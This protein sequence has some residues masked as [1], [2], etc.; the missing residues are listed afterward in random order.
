MWL[1]FLERENEKVVSLSDHL[2]LDM[3]REIQEELEKF[4]I[5]YTLTYTHIEDLEYAKEFWK[6][7]GYKV[8]GIDWLAEATAGWH[9]TLKDKPTTQPLMKY[10]DISKDRRKKKKIRKRRK[11]MKKNSIH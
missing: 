3:T 11:E 10:E 8:V 2:L 6:R 1:Y 9:H 5:R 7:G 4:N